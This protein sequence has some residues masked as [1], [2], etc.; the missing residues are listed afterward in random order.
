MTVLQPENPSSPFIEGYSIRGFTISGSVVVGPCAV[1]PRAILQWNVSAG[2]EGT[3]T[4]NGA[5]MGPVWCRCRYRAAPLRTAL[6]PQVGSYQ[7]ISFQSLSLFRLLE[8][9]IGTWGSH[10]SSG[11]P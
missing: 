6:S 4:G 5:G 10:P 1:L 8:P 9:P 3:G 7:D 2:R 11:H